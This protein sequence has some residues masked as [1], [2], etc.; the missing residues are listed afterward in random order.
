MGAV[1]LLCLNEYYLLG[2]QN[3]GS[4]NSFF[5]F[6][7]NRLFTHGKNCML[8]MTQFF[9]LLSMCQNSQSGLSSNIFFN[10]VAAD[11]SIPLLKANKWNPPDAKWFVT[12]IRVI[13][14]PNSWEIFHMALPLAKEVLLIFNICNLESFWLI[15]QT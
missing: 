2:E 1:D 5:L 8:A 14:W 12:V 3:M 13:H 6:L 15:H 10:V 11:N 4:I 7:K 9:E